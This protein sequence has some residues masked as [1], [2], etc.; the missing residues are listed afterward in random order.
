MDIKVFKFGGASVRDAEQIRNVTN[1]LSH[2]KEEKIVLVV[3]AMGKTTNALEE[4]VESYFH[5]DGLAKSKVDNILKAHFEVADQLFN[6]ASEVKSLINDIYL[7]TSVGVF[8]IN[9]QMDFWQRFDN[10]LPNV[11]IMD[12]EINV[13]DALIT[14]GTYGRGVW[15]SPIEVQKATND[16]VLLAVNSNNSVQCNDISPL[17]T[18][19]NNGTTALESIDVDY[20][21][22]GVKYNTQISLA[23]EPGET[24][25][26]ELPIVTALDLGAYE[27]KIET[28]VT[29]DAFPSNNSL[30][31]TF[32]LNSIGEGNYVNTFGDVEEDGWVTYTLG[33][34][35]PL[36][37]K[38][39]VTTKN[40]K[41]KFDNAYTTNLSG[42][43][44]D[45]SMS[46][47]LSP[48]YDLSALID[49]VLK[50]DMA[51][52]IEKDWDVLYLEY[53]IDN[54]LSWEILG[55]SEDPNWYNSNFIDPQRPLTVGKQWTGTDLEPKTYSY[56]LSGLSSEPSV[57]FRFVFGADQSVNDEGVV[58][59]NF[60]IDASAI[61]AVAEFDRNNYQL[62]PNP[63][64]G[65]FLIN[66]KM[67]E[68]MDLQVYDI[69]GRLIREVQ[70]VKQTNYGLDLSDIKPGLYFLKLKEGSKVMSTRLLL[71]AD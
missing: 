28:S 2:F 58:I 45:N 54:G 1:I 22:N 39:L 6:D 26:L 13:E 11:P 29:N 43:Y 24:K 66:R 16:L 67:G 4:V 38:G 20:F 32:Q 47:L 62:Y 60:T 12:M 49:P 70:N 30:Q 5:K 10:G 31:A 14:V 69:T 19:K 48:C 23:L 53:S 63:S 18:V 61:L 8:H 25:V 15:Q 59:D 57:I 36:W 44:S 21:I 51:F 33:S 55:S 65:L 40:L 68:S 64:S 42:N 50:F 27:L 71:T 9:D 46:F 52:S 3:S 7:G 17:I 37:E 34:E 35:N 56:D 41:E